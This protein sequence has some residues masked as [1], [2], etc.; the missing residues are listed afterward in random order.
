MVNTNDIET[1]NFWVIF[2]NTLKGGSFKFKV[3]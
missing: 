3:Q 2:K 1:S